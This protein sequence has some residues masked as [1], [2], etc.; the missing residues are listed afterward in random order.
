MLRHQMMRTL[1][2]RHLSHN[3]A[4]RRAR[5]I[6]VHIV[7]VRWTLLLWK[8]TLSALNVE[9][10]DARVVL[11]LHHFDNNLLR[12]T[13]KD[14][15]LVLT[16]LEEERNLV[17]RMDVHLHILGRRNR[18]LTGSMPTTADQ[19]LGESWVRV[20]RV[21]GKAGAEFG[22]EVQET[23]AAFKGLTVPRAVGQHVLARGTKF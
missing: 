1:A 7:Q 20:G 18:Q 4:L 13:P 5:G 11:D 3:H 10:L 23:V 8:P 6:R 21:D 2:M 22:L 15:L 16:V 9:I 14:G 12:R 17:G 19:A